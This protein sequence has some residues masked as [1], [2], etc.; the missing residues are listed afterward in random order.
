[1][2]QRQQGNRAQNN[3]I[4]HVVPPKSYAPWSTIAGVQPP[5]RQR[6]PD[7]RLMTFST[8]RTFQSQQ[9]TLVRQSVVVPESVRVAQQQ[10][11]M[12]KLRNTHIAPAVYGWLSNV[13]N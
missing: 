11:H 4:A 12:Q 1:M 6:T 13:T 8:D 2:H 10:R 5:Q 7:P 9:L 3:A